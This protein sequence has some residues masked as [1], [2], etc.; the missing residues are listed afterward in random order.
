ME[1]AREVSQLRECR[2]KL[3]CCG[4]SGKQAHAGIVPGQNTV[5]GSQLPLPLSNSPALTPLSRPTSNL[6][7]LR[8][9]SSTLECQGIYLFL[10]FL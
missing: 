10:K 7:F 5:P 6:T 3:K 9:P 8:K 4:I 2:W 1:S